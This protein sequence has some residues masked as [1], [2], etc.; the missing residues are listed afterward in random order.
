VITYFPAATLFLFIVIVNPGPSVP[1]SVTHRGVVG[2][3]LSPQA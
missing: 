3:T 1:V 2:P